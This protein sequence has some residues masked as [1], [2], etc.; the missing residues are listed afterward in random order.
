V[1]PDN[2]RNQTLEMR[3][4]QRYGALS[5]QLRKAADFVLEHPLDIASRSLRA[6]A[7]EC[8]VSPATFSRLA[9]ALGYANFEEMKTVARRTVGKQ[10]L[11]MSER[12]ENL[13]R[14]AARD[15]AML[16]RQSAACI[17]NIETFAK[18]LDAHDL[19]GA[20]GALRCANKVVLFG[21]LAS[22][23]MVEY[24]AYLAQFFAPNWSLAGRMGASVGA[25]M[26]KLEQGDVVFIVTMAPFAKNA[27]TAARMARASG[28]GVILVTDSLTCPALPHATHS[29]VVPSESPQFFSSYAVTLVLIET[30]IA[31][32]VA[33]S[34]AEATAAIRKIEMANHDLGEYWSE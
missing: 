3:V 18:R 21:A 30:L 12:A 23:G 31:M 20:A 13:R 34:E 32:I 27:I 17:R 6:I 5:G 4:A 9:R 15:K 8:G 11:G 22:T 25:Q 7:A 29:F 33:A 24:M 26:A 16:A 14:G 28:A 1:I 2:I 10:V 19:E